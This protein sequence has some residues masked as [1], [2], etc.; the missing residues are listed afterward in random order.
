MGSGCIGPRFL[1]LGTRRRWVVS[2]TPPIGGWLGPRAGKDDMEKGKFLTLFGLELRPLRCP[3][4]GQSLYRMRNLGSHIC[5][6]WN[7]IFNCQQILIQVSSTAFH[8]Y[9]VSFF[10]IVT[11]WQTYRRTQ[12]HKGKRLFYATIRLESTTKLWVSFLLIYYSVFSTHIL[13]WEGIR[14]EFFEM[15]W[16]KVSCYYFPVGMSGGTWSLCVLSY[17]KALGTEKASASTQHGWKNF[18]S[19]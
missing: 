10:R 5:S 4:R 7:K 8:E 3:A 6:V 14:K 2:F 11:C 12:R 19:S 18:K 15:C 16:F 17:D 9:L 13:C 1:D